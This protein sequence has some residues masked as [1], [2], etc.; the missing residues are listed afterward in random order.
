MSRP[1][2]LTAI[3]SASVVIAPAT[4]GWSV[5][6][7][8][9]SICTPT[10]LIS[11][12]A[13]F[14]AIAMPLANPPPPTGTITRRRSGTSSSSSSPSVACPAT[15]AGSSKGWMKAIPSSAARVRA[16]VTAASTVSPLS[17]TVAPYA[18]VAS[19]LEIEAPS[20]T[21]ISHRTPRCRAA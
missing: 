18:R 9:P 21:K 4:T 2:C 8:H 16:A 5:Y 19:V 11:A 1:G 7:A 12:S 17:R 13:R 6:G 14:S 3:P 20:G 15:M 10:T